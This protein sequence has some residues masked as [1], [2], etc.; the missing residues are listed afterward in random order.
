MTTVGHAKDDDE[1][2]R[3]VQYIYDSGMRK[4]FHKDDATGQMVM[5]HYNLRSE[6]FS[7]HEQTRD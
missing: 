3:R 1:F 2:R 5:S 4:L 6:A 7:V